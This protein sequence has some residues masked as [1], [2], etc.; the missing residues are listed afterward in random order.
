MQVLV[1][2]W[3]REPQMLHEQLQR[4][5]LIRPAR[6]HPRLCCERLQIGVGNRLQIAQHILNA[7]VHRRQLLRLLGGNGG[8]HVN[9][10]Q[11]P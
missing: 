7:Y 6:W 3:S 11:Q 4:L 1:L 9:I 10:L 2:L 8:L 5:E